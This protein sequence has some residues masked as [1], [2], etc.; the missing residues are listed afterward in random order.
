MKSG[1]KNLTEI[2]VG[3]VPTLHDWNLS[4]KAAR[5]LQK[6]LRDEIRTDLEIKSPTRIAGVDV[7]Y[8]KQ[9][10]QSIASVCVLTYPTLELIESTTART[11]TPFP[12]VPGLLSFR[13]I[14]PILQALE[15]TKERVDLFLVDGH[16]RAHPRRIGIASHLGLWLK[17]PTIGIGKSRLCGEFRNPA[18]EK[19]S[20]SD[21]IDDGELVGKVLRSRTGVRPI[22]VSVG[23]GLPLDTCLAWTQR[24]ITRYRLPEPI[25]MA[26]RMAAKQKIGIGR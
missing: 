16:G 6:R 13:E 5:R 10:R 19:G 8:L 1:G 12:Y 4:P 20:V 11:E 21:L 26:D 9:T 24:T 15:G 2:H 17:K 22:F 18:P 3:L 14:P 23:Y 7:A 25:R